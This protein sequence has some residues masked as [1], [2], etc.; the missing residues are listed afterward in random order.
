MS[1]GKIYRIVGRDVRGFL[2]AHV[3]SRELYS[4]QGFSLISHT[5][6]IN[7]L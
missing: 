6:R 7:V 4:I 5:N 3:L 2:E 1:L